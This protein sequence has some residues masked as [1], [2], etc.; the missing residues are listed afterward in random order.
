MVSTSQHSYVRDLLTGPPPTRMTYNRLGK[1]GLKVSSIILG[2]MSFGSKDWQK[3]V[4]EEDEALPLLGYAYDV[5]INTWDTSDLYSN[6]VSEEIIAKAL[7]TYKIPRANVVLMTKCRSAISAPG[8]PQLSVFASTV[9]DGRLVNRAGLSRKHILDAAQASVKRLGT[10]IDVF[11]IQRMD[12]DVPREEIMKALNDVVEMGLA[13][14]IG[15]S[16][17]PAWEFQ[18][19]QN[20]AKCH[21]WHQFISMQ[22]YYNLL[23]REEEREM[24]PYCKDAGVGCIPWSPVARGILARPW[25]RIDENSSLRSQH[26]V[27][28]TR[29]YSRE[30]QVEKAIVEIVEEIANE[31]GVPMAVIATAWCLA[32]G[33]NPIVGLNSKDRIDDAVLAAKTILSE[34]EIA[35]L[36]SAYQPRPVTGY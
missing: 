33:V 36:E 23:Y 11:Q 16:S 12:P 15:A 10:Y 35:R 28:L 13:R 34:R 14:Y 32:K 29:L 9:N 30:S 5:G 3:W 31:R 22:N 4:L 8:E 2:A 7:T 6:G 25:N 26:D 21:G 20:V 24:I 1:S 17:M 18:A 27:A 19:L